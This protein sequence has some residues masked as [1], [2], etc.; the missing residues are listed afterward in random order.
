[1]E[2]PVDL[3]H[4]SQPLHKEA[5]R[6]RWFAKAFEDQVASTSQDT[7]IEFDLDRSKLTGVFAEWLKDFEAQKPTNPADKLAY[8]G[9][10]AGLMLR[11]LV[12]LKPVRIA[13]IPANTDRSNPAFYWPEGYLYV[14]F[15]LN[16]RSLV[17][18]SDFQ[19]EQH[20]SDL[21]HE[22][23]AWWSFKE[24]IEEDPSLAIAFLD[25]FAGDDPDWT[26]PQ[27]FRTGRV[28]G[29]ASR[30]YKLVSDT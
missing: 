26:M 4:E 10:A 25:L 15:C 24:N 14:A 2:N 7:Q 30:F 19:D 5:Q 8:V 1:M 18:K 27:V 3:S 11:S 23:S 21:L 9:F 6:L 13:T 16:V 12:Q 29:V 28:Q 22:T 20:Q 17:L